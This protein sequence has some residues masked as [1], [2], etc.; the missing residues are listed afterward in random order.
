MSEQSPSDALDLP[1][2]DDDYFGRVAERLV[3]NF[4]LETDVSAGGEPFDLGGEL[5]IEREKHFLHPSMNYANHESHEYLYARRQDSVT[6]ADLER[7]AD[8]GSD[9]AED[10]FELHDEH[11][12]TDVTFVL[13]VPEVSSDVADFVE[14]FSGRTLVRWGFQGHYEINLVV[15]APATE[16]LVASE[17][18][19]VGRAF[20][21]WQPMEAVENRGLL[22]RIAQKLRG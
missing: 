5:R 13:I 19:D 22:R 7:L 10:R 14:G 6:V 2:W 16:T 18:A 11:F 9:L 1:E 8:L 4:D 21:T 12:S 20:R 3:Y 15:V 17:N